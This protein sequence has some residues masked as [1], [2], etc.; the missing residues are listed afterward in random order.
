[1]SGQSLQHSTNELSL[2]RVG[3]EPFVH[4]HAIYLYLSS[5]NHALPSPVQPPAMQ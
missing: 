5:V 3:R 2:S 1:M 4:R